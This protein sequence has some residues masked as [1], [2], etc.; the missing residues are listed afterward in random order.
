MR[1][2]NPIR[3][4]SLE[5]IRTMVLATAGVA[6]VLCCLPRNACAQE[7]PGLL[8]EEISCR[9]ATAIAQQF[10]PY[11]M[12]WDEPDSLLATLDWWETNCGS[13]EP[14]RRTRILASIW[15]DAFTEDMYDTRVIQDLAWRYDPERLE[16]QRTHRYG[17]VGWGNVASVV[18]FT[19]G[20]AEYDAFTEDIADQLLP[21][22]DPGSVEEFFCLFY[23]GRPQEA[24]VMLQ[25]SSLE[26]TE[27]YD[28]YYDELATLDVPTYRDYW[29]ARW[30]YRR[31]MGELGNLGNQQTLGAFFGRR[32]QHGSAELDLGVRLGRADEPYYVT[33]GEFYGF[34][35][36]Y[37]GV[38]LGASFGFLLKRFGPVAWD[39][40][41]DGAI[42]GLNPFQDEE[43]LVLTF[44][45]GSLGTVLRFE[46]GEAPRWFASLDWR[47]TW[48]SDPPE[49]GTPLGGN[50]WS[51]RLSFGFYLQHPNEKKL[52]ALGG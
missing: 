36:R 46:P 30:G 26:G 8:A 23:S 13:S 6:G 32:W 12:V 45:Q 41:V 10:V 47:R 11:F 19:P 25:G 29:G 22:A 51:T 38:H 28:R 5:L 18:D 24:Y 37:A 52:A 14:V 43:D 17:N 42:E 39:A 9:D 4:R 40:V 33:E 20:A 2:S 35:D 16:A 7:M 48:I 1:S 27:L 15:D 44:A 34:S 3:S 21:H 49:G 31:A 50:A